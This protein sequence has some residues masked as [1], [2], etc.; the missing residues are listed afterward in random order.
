MGGGEG[1][2]IHRK[3][4]VCLGGEEGK[5][6]VSM[7]VGTVAD[8]FFLFFLSFVLPILL[9]SSHPLYS[10]VVF[11][12]ASPFRKAASPAALPNTD[13]AYAIF[14]R[15]AAIVGALSAVG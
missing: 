1:K 8:V 7:R 11:A 15:S 4:A 12:V 3:A 10:F 14:R 13:G 2:I 9:P 5:R 6:G